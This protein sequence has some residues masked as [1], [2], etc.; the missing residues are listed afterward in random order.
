MEYQKS[1]L[2]HLERAEL[3]RPEDEEICYQKARVKEDLYWD[4]ADTEQKTRPEILESS[5]AGY[6][7]E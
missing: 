6:L 3:R 1:A 7:K 5:P 2:E 4:Y